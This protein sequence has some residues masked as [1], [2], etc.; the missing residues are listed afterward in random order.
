MASSKNSWDEGNLSVPACTIVDFPRVTREEP[1]L[2]RKS[3]W[4][5]NCLGSEHLWEF[6]HR[7]LETLQQLSM[8]IV[9]RLTPIYQRKSASYGAKNLL[10]IVYTVISQESLRSPRNLHSR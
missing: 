6:N 3:P 1:S 2:Q 4:I 7:A 9:D 8:R 10:A 5:D